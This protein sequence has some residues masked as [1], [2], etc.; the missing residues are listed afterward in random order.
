MC[1]KGSSWRRARRRRTFVSVSVT[2][3]ALVALVTVLSVYN[4][5]YVVESALGRAFQVDCVEIHGYSHL[6]ALDVQALS[7]WCMGQPIWRVSPKAVTQHIPSDG[8]IQSVE[9]RRFLPSRVEMHIV[10]R[11]PVAIICMPTPMCIDRDGTVLC[12]SAFARSALL[13]KITGFSR[14]EIE[15][16][17]RSFVTMLSV[18][19]VLQG[20]FSFPAERIAELSIDEDSRYW[21]R[22]RGETVPVLFDPTC[23]DVAQVALCFSVLGDLR[24][25]DVTA[26]FLDIR[27]KGQIVAVTDATDGIQNNTRASS[28]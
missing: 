21:I 9:V 26:H 24:N 27:F 19:A 2:L 28:G 18:A 12:D 20:E 8:W 6:S 25:R 7:A 15:Q 3:A 16:R 23:L 13:P 5:G 4:V 11:N 10:E 22:F 1:G 17:A 14:E